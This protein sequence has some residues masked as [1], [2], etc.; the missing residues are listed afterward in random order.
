MSSTGRLRRYV[1]AAVLIA[2]AVAVAAGAMTPAAAAPVGPVTA[3]AVG[4]AVTPADQFLGVSCPADRFCLGVG[5]YIPADGVK[6]P[7]AETWDGSAWHITF[8][9]VPS[10]APASVLQT[11]SCTSRTACLAVGDTNTSGDHGADVREAVR[12]EMGR[13]HVADGPDRRPRPGHAGEDVLRQRALLLRG[14]LPDPRDRCSLPG[15]LRALERQAVVLRPPPPAPAAQPAAGR[16]LPGP[17]ELL[18]GRVDRQPP[19]RRR[20]GR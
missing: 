11:V 18:G 8:P 19:H 16:V 6:R 1:R 13:Q 4:Q 17:A 10:P 9:L 3:V 12:G 2:P 5:W 15:H 7:L 20:S 14:G